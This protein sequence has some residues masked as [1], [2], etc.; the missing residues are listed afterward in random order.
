MQIARELCRIG[1]GMEYHYE[2]R[3]QYHRIQFWSLYW[4]GAGVS[5]MD[6]CMYIQECEW[7][8][9]EIVMCLLCEE[10]LVAMYVCWLVDL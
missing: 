2:C 8:G 3:I 4:E 1:V 9:S 7:Y 6:I 10:V 5:W